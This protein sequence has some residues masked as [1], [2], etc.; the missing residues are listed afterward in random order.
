MFVRPLENVT[1]LT[2]SVNTNI[3]AF[4]DCRPR[5]SFDPWN[6]LMQI[7]TGIVRPIVESTD[8]RRMFVE[9]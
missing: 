9:R 1:R 5:T 4:P 7:I 2:A 8:P 3:T 6:W